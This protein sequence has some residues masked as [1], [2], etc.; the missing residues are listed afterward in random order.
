ML[1][2]DTIGSPRL[3][4][5]EGEGPFVIQQYT[6][7]SFRDLIEQCARECGVSLER[8]FRARAS[9]DSVI[10]SRAGYPSTCLG[11]LSE[12]QLMS[13]YHLMTDVPENLDYGT[14]ADAARLVYAVGE[15]IAS[16]H[17]GR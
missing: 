3:I 4:M 11:S 2:L 14:I 13:N 8:G 15:A 12:W 16:G 10:T 17:A 1:N 6:D 7:P 9:T 5:L